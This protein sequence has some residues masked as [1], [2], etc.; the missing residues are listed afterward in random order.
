MA[1]Y[2]SFP[3]ADCVDPLC[4]RSAQLRT[5]PVSTRLRGSLASVC[6]FGDAVS[7]MQS[8]EKSAGMFGFFINVH[9]KSF[10]SLRKAAGNR[11]SSEISLLCREAA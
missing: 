11:I 4:N 5:L 8:V 10:A 2:L 3:G 7:G 1:Q 6:L 9:L